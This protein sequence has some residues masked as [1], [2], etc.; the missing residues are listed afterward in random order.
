MRRIVHGCSWR[1]G[2]GLG[3]PKKVKRSPLVR[4]VNVGYLLNC[5]FR[6]IRPYIWQQQ[7]LLTGWDTD[8]S[9]GTWESQPAGFLPDSFGF[10]VDEF[11]L[12]DVS[13][14]HAVTIRH[15]IARQTAGRITWSYRFKLPAPMEAACWQLRDLARAGGKHHDPRRTTVLRDQQPC[16]AAGRYPV[17]SRVWRQSGCRPRHQDCGYLC[18]RRIEGDGNALCAAGEQRRLSCW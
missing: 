15:Q 4:D 12:S 13:P 3:R 7:P 16:R 18:R 14:E 1:W 9:G 5:S 11:R 2:A 6:A 8:S 10:H 17:G